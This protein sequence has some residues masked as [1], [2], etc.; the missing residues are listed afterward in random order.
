MGSSEQAPRRNFQLNCGTRLYFGEPLI[1]LGWPALQAPVMQSRSLP[2]G[3][4][5]IKPKRKREAALLTSSP[6]LR[7]LC[8]RLLHGPQRVS[9]HPPPYTSRV[10][11]DDG[12]TNPAYFG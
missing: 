2:N 3:C 11:I 6:P 4:R 5:Y 12:Y 8:V 7:S 9:D 10:V 1:E